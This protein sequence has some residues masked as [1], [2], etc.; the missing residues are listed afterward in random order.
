MEK[1]TMTF[2]MQEKG[3]QT[4]LTFGNL[5]VSSDEN[6]GFRPF[7]LMVASIVGCSGSVFRKI[8]QKQ[9]M[10]INDLTI[11]AEV[12]RNPDAANRIERINL[13]YTVKGHALNADKLHK[14]LALSRKHCPMIQSVQDSIHIEENLKVIDLSE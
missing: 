12:E 11:T 6:H 14:N 3:M 13:L 7:Q 4:E 10:T 2:D 9:R 5:D 8:L 1:T